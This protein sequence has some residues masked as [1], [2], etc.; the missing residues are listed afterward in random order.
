MNRMPPHID[1]EAPMSGYS[2]LLLSG[3]V[4]GSLTFLCIVMDLSAWPFTGMLSAFFFGV[5]AGAAGSG[6]GSE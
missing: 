3:M 2:L 1:P 6:K 4:L 5:A